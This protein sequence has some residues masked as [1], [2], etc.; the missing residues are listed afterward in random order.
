[1]CKFGADLP[2]KPSRTATHGERILTFP[3]A[4]KHT[5]EKCK[6][7][8]GWRKKT[9]RVKHSLLKHRQE[10]N[11]VG[12]NPLGPHLSISDP[13]RSS[14]GTGV[15]GRG[16]KVYPCFGTPALRAESVAVGLR[17]EKFVSSFCGSFR[18]ASCSAV[19]SPLGFVIPPVVGDSAAPF[20]LLSAGSLLA[21]CGLSRTRHFVSRGVR[22]R[23]GGGVERERE[24]QGQGERG[25]G[26]EGARR[27]K[28]VT[29][30]AR[31]V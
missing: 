12:P 3:P 14:G 23:E 2:R 15:P 20:P 24:A 5:C 1:M 18:P 26:R 27:R 8:R 29:S 16:R 11:V 28:C 13:R 4:P 21:S 17:R 22:E 7:V 25:G 30:P 10:S 19:G 6:R 9:T 31:G